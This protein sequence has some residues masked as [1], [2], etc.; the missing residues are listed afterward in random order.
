VFKKVRFKHEGDIMKKA[1]MKSKVMFYCQHVL[2]MGHLVRSMAL[3]EGLNQEFEVC[4]V[5]GGEIV[6]GFKTPSGVR[7]ENLPPL[8]SDEDFT[9][10]GGKDGQN[11]QEIQEARSQQLF[12]CYEDFQPDLIVIELFPF[13]RKKF[14]FELI[15]LLAR[16]RLEGKSKIVCSLRDILVQKRDQ[17][18]HEASVCNTLNRYFDSVVI[19]ADPSFQ[20]LEETFGAMHNINIPIQYTGYVIQGEPEISEEAIALRSDVPLF[21]ASIGGGR[22]GVELLESSI[23]AS[24]LLKEELEHQLLIF[25]GP[26]LPQEDFARL[27]EKVASQ[28]QIILKRFTATFLKYIE[29]VTV[30]ISMAGYNTCMNILS[31]GVQALVLPFAGGGND[32]QGSRA[33]KLE[34]LGLLGVLAAEKLNGEYLAEKIKERLEPQ[35]VRTELNLQGVA[36]TTQL[37][38]TLAKTPKASVVR[39]DYRPLFETVLT[40]HLELLQA[41]G[42]TRPVFLR[43]DDGNKDEDTLRQLFDITLSNQ[44]PLHVAVIPTGLTP[45]GVRLLKDMKRAGSDLVE[46]GQHGY[47]HL[48]HESEGRKCEFGA[49]RSFAEQF[50]DIARGKKILEERLLEQFAPIFTPPWNRC[51]KDTFKALEQLGFK[52]LSKDN[53]VPATGYSFQEVSITLDLY[54]WKNG[55]RMKEPEVFVSELVKQLSASQ[56]VGLLLHHKVMDTAAFD[57]LD[58]L[59]TELKRYPVLEFCTL[60]SLVA[61]SKNVRGVLA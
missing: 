57:F 1:V 18:K 56:P 30:S 10:L 49:S 23:E 47:Q 41:K 46:L 61:G 42:R 43:N 13:G 44:V 55:A 38:Q 29:R 60:Q 45:A 25:T 40:P 15:P 17:A 37:L 58:T 21:L 6:D 11:L 28:P 5:N 35:K 34:A 52:I 53:S 16:V 54:T 4:F 51:T 24:H 12:K 7:L 33:R 27:Q 9:G 36:T 48:N 19:H 14:A 22:V 20:R 3:V 50:E 59:L 31:T 26:Y 2:G 39:T 8:K 32:E